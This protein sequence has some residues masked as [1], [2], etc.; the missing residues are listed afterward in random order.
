[1]I[2]QTHTN[3]LVLD[4]KGER[5]VNSHDFYAAFATPEEFRLVAGG[6]TLGTLPIIAPVLEG[7]YLIFG[8]RRW[9]VLSV[10]GA[11]KLIELAPAAEVRHRASEGP[12]RSSTIAFG[13]RCVG[14]T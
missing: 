6:K 10:D 7:M 12:G 5:L 1:M 2:T 3:E 9:R 11:H 14:C 13:R 4:L 8:G